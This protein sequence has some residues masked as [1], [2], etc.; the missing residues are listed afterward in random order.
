MVAVLIY[1][2]KY[3]KLKLNIYLSYFLKQERSREC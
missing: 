2:Y 3:S 1:V